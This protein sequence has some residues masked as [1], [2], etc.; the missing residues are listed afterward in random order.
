[1]IIRSPRIPVPRWNVQMK[2]LLNELESDQKMRSI[3]QSVQ[4]SLVLLQ[5]VAEELGGELAREFKS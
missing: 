1:M 3:F 4:H 2:V 5:A